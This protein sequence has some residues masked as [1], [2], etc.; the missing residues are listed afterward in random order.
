M[1]HASRGRCVRT[2]RSK[3]RKR[4]DRWFAAVCGVATVLPIAVLLGLLGLVVAIGLAR[5]DLGFLTGL[6]SRLPEQAGILAG[7]VGTLWLALITA[8]IAVPVG[9]GTAIYLE[10]YARA[11]ATPRGSRGALVWLIEGSIDNLT[12]VPSLIYGLFG[13][14]IFARTLGLGRSL[15]AGGLTLAL[16]V[17]PLVILSARRALRAVSPS[18]RFAAMALG[19]SRWQ[20]VR[21]IV[22]PVAL[23][24]V[25][26]GSIL[27][28]SRAIGEA[29]PLVVLGALVYVDVLPDGPS[30]SF[31]AL[32]VQV[33]EWVARGQEGFVV[34]AAAAIGV[35]LV[36][37]LGLNLGALFIRRRFGATPSTEVS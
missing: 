14:E 25:V 24:E 1:A 19:A 20:M 22:L 28:V 30:S 11:T 4:A 17:L 3:R 16:L 34:H 5:L 10:E 9:L 2:L 29:A 8:G 35:L 33:F 26:S 21:Q 12:G 13:L 15:W 32:P 36:L 6:P 27:A 37:L 31:T 7:L 18:L 23:P